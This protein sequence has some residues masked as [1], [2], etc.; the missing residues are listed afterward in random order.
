[1]I[2]TLTMLL[3]YF[4]V[5]T[6]MN[7]GAQIVSSAGH[8]DHH[9]RA[10]VRYEAH[11]PMQHI[12]GYSGS[13]WTPPLGDYSLHI[14]PV[15]ARATINNWRCK[16]PPLCW[17]FRWQWQGVSTIPHRRRFM[18]FLKATKCRHRTST[19]SDIP[20]RTCL[21][22]I[23]GVYFIVKSTKRAQVDI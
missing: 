18:A 23:L 9:G 15:A 6:Y 8:F 19:C 11:C 4:Y 17:P 1:M 5:E 21:P 12:Q 22:L 2:S 16:I 7:N 3:G 14:A 13:H 10:P 20:T